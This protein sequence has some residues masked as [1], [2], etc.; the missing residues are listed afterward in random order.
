[1]LV[2]LLVDLVIFLCQELLCITVKQ[3]HKP[4][5]TQNPYK[6]P[7]HGGIT[8]NSNVSFTTD[9]TVAKEFRGLNGMI[10]QIDMK[11]SLNVKYKFFKSCDVSWISNYPSEKEILAFRG[12]HFDFRFSSIRMDKESQ[13]QW[14]VCDDDWI[15]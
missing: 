10:L 14:I 2:Q 4:K 15:V 12:S 6:K 5:Q 7:L 13:N 8:F 11:N 9:A 3:I 1:M